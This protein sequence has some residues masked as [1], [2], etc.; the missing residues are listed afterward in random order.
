MF[1]GCIP[2]L[3]AL[4]RLVFGNL[5]QEVEIVLIAQAVA[6]TLTFS[7]RNFSAVIRRLMSSTLRC[8]E[9]ILLNL[10]VFTIYRIY[11]IRICLF[12]INK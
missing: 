12:G 2:Y 11:E 8:S 3:R 9:F 7:S 4:S 1:F 5:K 6:E 10:T